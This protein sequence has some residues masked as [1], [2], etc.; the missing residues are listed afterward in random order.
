MEK[1][2]I[3]AKKRVKESIKDNEEKNTE[4]FNKSGILN[5]MLKWF[6]KDNA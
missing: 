5:T 3:D 1:A 2:K 6:S 4:C